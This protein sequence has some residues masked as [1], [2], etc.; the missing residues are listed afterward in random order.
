MP[1]SLVNAYY[2]AGTNEIAFPAGILQPPF[3]DAKAPAAMNYGAM[4]MVIGH[5][6]THGFDDEGRH[7]DKTGRMI[8]WWAPE[9]ATRFEERA[10][11]VGD[12]Y[13]TYEILPGVKVNGE[14]TMGENLADIGGMKGAWRAYG[15]WK[16]EHGEP[17]PSVP[18]LTDDQLF[19]VS[20]AQGWCTKRTPEYD[21]MLATADPHSPP[22]FRVIGT[23]SNTPAFAEAFKCAP[24]TP[25]HPQNACEVW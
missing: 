15:A 21:R 4:G 2:N 17:V 12:L 1:P 6:I 3:F 18:G 19:F 24:G 22:K 14:L 10:K 13:S 11:C 9:V 8:D 20:F 16:A 5:E 7:Y 25:M 23:V